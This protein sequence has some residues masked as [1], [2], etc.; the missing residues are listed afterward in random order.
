VAR[1]RRLLVPAGVLAVLGAC[2]ACS[3]W[4]WFLLTAAVYG[5]W[6]LAASAASG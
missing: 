1:D 4:R 5:M 2:F 3:P 6:D